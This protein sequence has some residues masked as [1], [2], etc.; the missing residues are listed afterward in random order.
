MYVKQL[1]FIALL[2]T[3]MLAAVQEVSAQG[4]TTA[5]QTPGTA[6]PVC[7]TSVFKQDYVPPCG[8]NLV[9]VA[10]ND[11]AQYS[12]KNP[13]YYKFTCFAT[14]TLGF[15]I[16]PNTN[17]DDYDWQ[18][19]DITG[20]SPDDIFSMPNLFVSGNW[21]SNSGATGT[22]AGGS[23]SVNCAGPTYP[24]KNAL[25][26]LFKGHSY[27]LL[28]SH[29]TN[30]QSGYSL[31]FGGGTASITDT[32]VPALKSASA[33]CDGSKIQ[34]ILNKSMECSSLAADGSDFV[35]TG[36][37]PGVK[38]V[39]AFAVNCNG[40]DLDTL[41]AVLNSPLANGTFGMMMNTGTDGN[42]LI[43]ICGTAIPVGQSVPFTM[44]QPQPT[45]LDSLVPP[46][47]APEVLTL[48]FPKQIYCSSIAAD[49]SDF[50]VQGTSPVTV[51]GASGE[52]DTGGMTYK[53]LVKLSAPIQ[54]AGNFRIILAPGSDGNTLTDACGLPSPPGSLSFTTG[55]TVD[56]ALLTDQVF[57]GCKTDTIL[58]E[59]PS[60]NGVNQWQWL[61]DGSD[62]SLQQDPPA[63][64]YSVFNTKNAR[65][66]V[67]NGYCTD[68]ASLSPVLGNAISAGLEVPNLLCP[69]D[70][71][72][73]ANKSTGTLNSWTWNFGD[74]ALYSGETPPDHL[75]PLTGIEAKYTVT[76]VVGNALG[77]YDT[78]AQ[79]I[80]VL[81]S[82]YIAVP[83]AFTP[84]GDGLNDY[85]YPLN[86]Y[87]ADNLTFKVF[88]RYGQMVFES[89]EWTQKW[90]GTVHGHAEPAGTYVW[91]LE[92][93]DRDTGKKIFQKGTSL[94]IR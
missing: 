16:D 4:C 44:L 37:P 67:S 33:L 61:F 32:T 41:I 51:I 82:C 63:R 42:T 5:G 79:Q 65:L 21:S 27:L 40:F 30:S 84:N 50:T 72:V 36:A 55:D 53:V 90:D 35:L 18:L 46:G 6:F 71:A 47:C 88:N 83:G 76:L 81:R 23:G 3:G 31:S 8:G 68:T 85:L 57:L 12:D 62:T 91:M 89:H 58:Y 34:V 26:V 80:D 24:N 59:Y 15:L 39:G 92:Y 11:A 74:G 29:F 9:P 38:V 66:I 52:C 60:V 78:A 19:F 64:L 70:Y 22:A 73:F 69:K 7:G 77:C 25:P 17:S 14:G 28:V 87:K 56:A 86:A 54:T 75:Y 45:P 48:V 2:F 93:V 43:D 49:G 94:L 1:L 10:C 20:H 13:F